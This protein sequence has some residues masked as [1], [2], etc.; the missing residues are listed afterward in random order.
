MYY[1][2][3]YGGKVVGVRGGIF[4][5]VVSMVFFI[6]P[7]CKRRDRLLDRCHSHTLRCGR[8]VGTTRGGVSLDGRLRGSTGARCGPGLSTKTGFGCANGPVRLSLSLPSLSGPLRFR[9]QRVGCKTSIS[10]ARPLCAKKHVHR[11][12]G[13]TRTRDHLTLGR[14]R[15]VGSSVDCRTSLH[16]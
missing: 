11:K 7:I 9:K 4:R 13:G 12:I 6:I 8:S 10:L 14:S 2:L 3:W 16:C 5:L 1:V 15:V